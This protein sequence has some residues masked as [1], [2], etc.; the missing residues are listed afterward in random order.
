[1]AKD[2]NWAIRLTKTMRRAGLDLLAGT[3]TGDPY[4]LP[5]FSLHDELA[6]LVLAGLTPLESIQSAT[7][8]PAMF[9]GI[10]KTHGTI[11]PGKTA[12]LV[13]LNADP[14]ADIRNTRRIEAVIKGGRLY[15]RK[16]LNAM[17][18]KR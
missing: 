8:N 13:L 18:V 14:L 3:D 1:M 5:G 9:F 2:F 16:E 7:R 6:L 4:V 12:D 15:T 10:E 17:L 11:E